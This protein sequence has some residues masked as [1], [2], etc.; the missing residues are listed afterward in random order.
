[1]KTEIKDYEDRFNEVY[2]RRELV[3]KAKKYGWNVPDLAGWFV[4]VFVQF[5]NEVKDIP[6]HLQKRMEINPS[7]NG[8]II[9]CEFI[10]NFI[11]IK[12]WHYNF[13]DLTGSTK[14]KKGSKSVLA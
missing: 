1:M 11:I 14:N 12:K 13:I 2:R 4:H 10:M 5:R 7:N 3:V 9:F 8:T 6:V